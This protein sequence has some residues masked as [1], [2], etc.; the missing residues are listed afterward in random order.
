MATLPSARKL[1]TRAIEFQNKP[2]VP[3]DL[4]IGEAS[5][6]LPGAPS[7]EVNP[8]ANKRPREMVCRLNPEPQGRTPSALGILYPGELRGRIIISLGGH[9]SLLS[10]NPTSNEPCEIRISDLKET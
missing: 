8:L 10:S 3:G 2:I 9:E 6:G 7:T 1:F 4:Y 5:A